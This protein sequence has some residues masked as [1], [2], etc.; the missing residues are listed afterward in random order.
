MSDRYI[1][2]CFMKTRN[3]FEIVATFT[4]NVIHVFLVGMW[5]CLVMYVD[6]I[7]VLLVYLRWKSCRETGPN[8]DTNKANTC[9]TQH[10]RH[11]ANGSKS[12]DGLEHNFLAGAAEKAAT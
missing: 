11:R 9:L 2:L 3:R 1:S 5:R 10:F 8:L 6:T 12:L 7:E 4:L